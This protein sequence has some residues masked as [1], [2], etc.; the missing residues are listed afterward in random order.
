VAAAMGAVDG[1]HAWVVDASGVALDGLRTKL[2]D[3][4]AADSRQS[5]M[6]VD[7]VD[8]PIQR[9]H[10]RLK[11]ARAK[12]DEGQPV[13]IT[14]RD[15]IALWGAKSRGHRLDQRIEADLANHGLTTSP[16]FRKVTLDTPVMMFA[17]ASRDA[18]DP[19][20]SQQPAVEP[21]DGDE[22]DVGLTVGN[23]SSA[24]GGVVSVNPHASIQEA[25]TIMLVN[26]YSQLAVMSGTHSLSGAITWK[27]IAQARNA[28]PN[29]S[30]S[31]AVV[32]ANEVSYDKDLV[33]VLPILEAADFVFVRDEKRA[34]AG[35]VTN[36]DVVHAYGELATP[37]FLIGELD[38]A[39]RQVV[40]KTYSL[41]EVSSCCDADGSRE[42]RS[43]DE[44]TMGDYQRM[45]ENPANWA[46]LGWPLE[47]STIIRRLDELREIRNDI[48]HFNPDPV[49][50]DAVA[51]LRNFTR[52]LRSYG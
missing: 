47:R 9:R 17:M 1:W 15:L 51:K 36:A 25:I 44:L 38:Q 24:L 22:V 42:I 2:L 27:S 21:E 46:K 13:E 37:F 39:L 43:F 7:D 6:D 19:T 14:V 34:V 52:L 31:D 49:P 35:I 3:S 28:N 45:L 50:P 18:D 4:V 8:S 32:E 12:A 11:E 10:T 26:D 40:A 23:L 5:P 48:M 30:F 29:A 16:N 33:D 41:S 20:D